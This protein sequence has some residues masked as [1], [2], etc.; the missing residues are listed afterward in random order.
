MDSERASAADGRR[1]SGGDAR[2]SG[3]ECPLGV[4]DGSGFV[5][6]EETNTASDCRCR[7]GRI[8]AARTRSLE[9]R[10]PR[11]YEGVSF[12]RPPVSDI[13]RTAPDQVQA[14]R[15]YV[16]RIGDN[17]D[18]VGAADFRQPGSARLTSPG[19]AERRS[20]ALSSR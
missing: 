11:R 9:G 17:L 14:V 2:H 10:L 19:R 13:A 4:C 15:R 16:R 7:S 18:A 5:I 6:E 3:G 12:E 1:R 8:A 20:A